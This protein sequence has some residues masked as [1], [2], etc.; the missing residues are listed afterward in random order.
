MA[1]SEELTKYGS[2]PR[3]SNLLM[4]PA[5]SFVCRVLNTRWPVR[6][7][8][9]AI[10]AVSASRTSP[11]IITS[12]SCRKTCRSAFTKVTPFLEATCIWLIPSSW[13]SIGSSTVITFFSAELMRL[14]QAYRVVLLPL[15][16]GPVTKIIPWVRSSSVSNLLR[17]SSHNPS[18]SSVRMP[19][20]LSKRRRTQRSP[21]LVGT[22]LTRRSISRWPSRTLHR[23]SCGIRRSAMSIPAITLI[24]ETIR[25]NTFL[26][27]LKVS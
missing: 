24:R 27:K 15:P 9:I 3:S 22:V 21:K 8:C 2:T 7:D 11:T 14:R 10:R 20:L 1:I 16:V 18:W 6:E 26:F 5:E 13:Y 25:G 4:A 23:P 12:G 17:S 19:E